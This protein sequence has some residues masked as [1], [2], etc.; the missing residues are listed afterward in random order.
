ML[1]GYRV[2]PG[3]YDEAFA[4]DG[5][6]RPHYRE[7]MT[8]LGAVDPGSL[9]NEVEEHLRAEGVTFGASEGGLLALDPVPR[10]IA[11]A[12][13][14]P[15]A[16]GIAQR[17]RALDEFA[18]DVYGDGAIVAE[19]HVPERVVRGS[20]HFEP[21]MRDAPD[22]GVWVSIVGFDL[23]RGADGC[24]RVLED[25]IRMPSGIAYAAAAREV[26][27]G[28][29]SLA[30]PSEREIAESFAVMGATLRAAAPAHVDD[31]TVVLLSGGAG[32]AGWYEHL[33]IG[34]E[35]GIG[36]VTLAD[37]ER[38]GSD[39]VVREGGST[40]RV[41]VVYLRSDEDRFTDADG[42]PTPIGELLLEP[43]R[44]GRVSVVN[45]P[46]TGVGD[47]KLV[48][49]YVEEMIRFYLGEEPVLES[50]ESFDLGVESRRDA[51][52]S[53]RDEL[54]F[55]PRGKMGGE[56]VV[57]W[58]DASEDERAAVT[59][60]LQRE[61]EQMIAQKRVELSTHPTLIEGRLEPRRVDL[62]PYLIRDSETEWVMPG[63]LT[64]VALKKG[65]LI[66]NSG[67]G[68]GV[69]DTWVLGAT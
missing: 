67:Q 27:A 5:R 29:L 2:P 19:G 62:R 26:V 56:G 6:P 10:L 47:D 55:K 33:R 43:S 60:A 17:G 45:A 14:E 49:A 32:A 25:Q 40:R 41:D 24:F 15:I 61:P 58:R 50:V 68:G 23:V 42:N 18:R 46:G 16:T 4:S 39:V 63:G 36:L 13:W 57:V 59:A 53:A 12:E 64:R 7:L 35:L 37:L 20:E 3:I 28:A 66:V 9:A 1:D 51:A 21:A 8:A 48:H 31:P 34:R 22:A 52:L 38:R 44:V 54:V 30:P 11:A 65:S 69:K